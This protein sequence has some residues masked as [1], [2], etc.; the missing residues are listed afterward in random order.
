MQILL[1]AFSKT[2]IRNRIR[3]HVCRYWFLLLQIIDSGQKQIADYYSHAFSPLI[4]GYRFLQH[5]VHNEVKDK[6]MFFFF[7]FN[8]MEN[9]VAIFIY[10][11]VSRRKRFNKHCVHWQILKIEVPEHKFN[12]F[13]STLIH[14]NNIQKRYL[15]DVLIIKKVS[16]LGFDFAFST[17][18]HV[19]SCTPPSLP[20]LK[21]KK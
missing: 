7:F 14:Y 15:F 21:K 17:S 20:K 2:V 12:N 13:I 10:L 5:A 19:M 16:G 3:I 9:S 1:I 18:W 4:R 8:S 11:S 6:N